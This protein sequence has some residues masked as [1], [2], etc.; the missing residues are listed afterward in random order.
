[1][2]ITLREL[3]VLEDG[4]GADYSEIKVDL[5]WIHQMLKH[6]LTTLQLRCYD[7]NED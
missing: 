3:A 5:A 4:F 6:R 7:D 1:M 2:A